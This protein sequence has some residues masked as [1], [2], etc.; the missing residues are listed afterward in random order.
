MEGAGAG[1]AGA[2]SVFA[3]AA[4]AAGAAG[5]LSDESVL[6]ALLSLFEEVIP[7]AAVLA[8]RL[9][10][11]YQP[12]PLKRIGGATKTRRAVSPHFSHGC[13]WGAS[14]PSRRSYR[15]PQLAQE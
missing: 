4:S 7:V 11:M 10:V 1:V 5:V 14:N 12:L 15:A 13:S 9:S 3:G 8:E 6:L 2:E